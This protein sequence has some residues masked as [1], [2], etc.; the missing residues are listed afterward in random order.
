MDRVILKD[1]RKQSEQV[2][3]L[4]PETNDDEINPHQPKKDR[5]PHPR[6]VDKKRKLR[7]EP[8]GISEQMQEGMEGTR[9]QFRGMGTEESFGGTGEP[10]GF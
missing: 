5:S 6:F 1:F 8:Y 7:P 9:N 2:H 3:L 4:Y 10:A